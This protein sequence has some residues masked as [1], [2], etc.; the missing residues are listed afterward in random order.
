MV[1]WS[2]QKRRLHGLEVYFINRTCW[3]QLDED[4]CGRL[5]PATDEG[6]RSI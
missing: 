4:E 5:P 3:E 2:S 6:S 1:L